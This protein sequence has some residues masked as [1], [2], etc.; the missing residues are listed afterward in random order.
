[1]SRKVVFR[2]NKGRTMSLPGKTTIS[3]LVK[4]GMAPKLVDEG[5][6]LPD[7]WWRADKPVVGKGV[8]K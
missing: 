7:N 2:N 1:M 5:A 3:Q 8:P 4:L 6:P